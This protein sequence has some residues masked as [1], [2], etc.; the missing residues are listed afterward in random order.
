MNILPTRGNNPNELEC[1]L[2]HYSPVSKMGKH[3]KSGVYIGTEV[4]RGNCAIACRHLRLPS[5]DLHQRTG[6]FCSDDP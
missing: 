5:E 2:P 1:V 4:S 6:P 3:Y